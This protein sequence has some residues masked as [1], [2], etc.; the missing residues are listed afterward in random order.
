VLRAAPELA[1]EREFLDA[2]LEA[3]PDKTL[4]LIAEMETSPHP[5]R[6]NPVRLPMHPD[7][8]SAEPGRCPSADEAAGHR[9]SHPASRSGAVHGAAPARQPR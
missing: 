2:W 8:T 9:A 1:A 3:P 7:V 5:G 6:A 4:A